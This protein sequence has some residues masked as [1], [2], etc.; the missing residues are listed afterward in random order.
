[1]I[2]IAPDLEVEDAMVICVS[3]AHSSKDVVFGDNVLTYSLLCG[4]FV[5]NIKRAEFFN[6]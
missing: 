5:K 1:M 2:F 4:C 6:L 3:T